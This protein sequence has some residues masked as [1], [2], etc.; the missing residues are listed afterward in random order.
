M[1][2]QIISTN[3]KKSYAMSEPSEGVDSNETT[4]I[5][6]NK[7][8]IIQSVD[9]NCCKMFGYSMG[10]LVGRPVKTL[11]P[12]PYQEQHDTYLKNYHRTGKAKV[13][14]RS[15]NV[16]GQHKDGTIFKIRL[17]VSE[18]KIPGSTIY[19]GMIEKLENSTAIISA[20]IKGNIVNCNDNC[21]TV[22]GY[23]TSELLGKNLSILMPNPYSNSH[24]E[25]IHNYLKTG[26]PNVIGRVR[27]VPAL[28]KDGT[29]FPI[30]LQ[31]QRV[32]C[33]DDTIFFRGKVDKVSEENELVFTLDCFGF[34]LSCNQ[35][36][37]LPLLGHTAGDL[38]GNHIGKILPALRYN[39]NNDLI[40]LIG[41]RRS[42]GYSMPTHVTKLQKRSD[43]DTV[44][45]AR[46]DV[47][48]IPLSDGNDSMSELYSHEFNE[49]QL[50]TTEDLESW[51]GT[52]ETNCRHC[53]GSFFRV[54]ITLAKF[55]ND[56]KTCFAVKVKREIDSVKDQIDKAQITSANV[57]SYLGSGKYSVS[58]ITIG[59]GSFGRVYLGKNE[60]SNEKVAVK[61]LQKGLMTEQELERAMREIRILLR[62]RHP[63]ICVLY[64]VS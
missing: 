60:I 33:D 14:G 48:S 52:S 8:G 61:L 54:S 53:D 3:C 24:D 16:E 6:I 9:N 57:V 12:P 15:R 45:H 28:H 27:N 18:I 13:I 38:K 43:D 51:I 19:V 29:I 40:S 1:G 58:E 39:K 47:V 2:D 64:D 37:A 30:C 34:I 26:T 23:E 55:V 5:T 17:S 10:E 35:N 21:K 63:N 42:S 41:K 32:Q 20:D 44:D 50:P 46:N 22:W 25:F 36:F 59:S 11:I 62:L 49:D 31:V 7:S 56:E 4:I